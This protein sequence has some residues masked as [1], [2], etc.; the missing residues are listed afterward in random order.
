MKPFYP[1][2]SHVVSGVLGAESS[3]LWVGCWAERI[4][5]EK[6]T[7]AYC[8][9][10]GQRKVSHQVFTSSPT[11]VHS[12]S[13]SND[14]SNSGFAPPWLKAGDSGKSREFQYSF[15]VLGRDFESFR[16]YFPPKSSLGSTT[17]CGWDLEGTFSIFNYI[18][19]LA[20]MTGRNGGLGVEIRRTLCIGA[21]NISTDFCG[22][23]GNYGSCDSGNAYIQ[24][25]FWGELILRFWA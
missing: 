12:P 8:S 13:P 10:I 9:L 17:G 15:V 4:G 22:F 19:S 14:H 5:L 11:P 21:Q 3:G 7:W 6:R 23:F 18:L 25:G 24:N 2:V 1:S 20:N 16:K